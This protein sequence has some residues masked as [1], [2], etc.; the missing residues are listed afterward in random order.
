MYQQLKCY[1]TGTDR[2]SDLNLGMGI[3]INVDRDWHGVR[4]PQVA[5]HLQL[6]H[7]LLYSMLSK[8]G[9]LS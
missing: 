5:V 8:L 7:F 1:K 3:V 2:L 9:V 6:S 4:R